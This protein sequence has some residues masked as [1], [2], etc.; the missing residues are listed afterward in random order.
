VLVRRVMS[1][2]PFAFILLELCFIVGFAMIG[3]WIAI[4]INQ[5]PV[6]GELLIG[7]ILGNIGYWLHRPLFTLIMH[8]E[9]V[10]P[11]ISDMWISGESVIQT[12][13]KLFTPSE[14]AP[15]GVGFKILE[16]ITSSG[17]SEWII[18]AAGLWLF[19]NLGVILLLFMVGLEARVDEM[20]SVG[21]HSL[22]VAVVGVVCP[23]LLGAGASIFLFPDS[24]SEV[25]L[26]LGAVLTATSVGITARVFKDLNQLKTP[27]ARLVLGAA[28]IDDILGLL[29]LSVVVGIVTAGTLE[30]FKIAYVLVLSCL[31]LGTVVMFGDRVV[32]WCVPIVSVLDRNYS[33]LLF[34]LTLAFFLSWVTDLIGLAT[35]V[36]AFAAGLILNEEYFEKHSKDKL[37]LNDL[38]GPLE[39]VFAPVFFVLVGMRV[40]LVTFL[41]LDVILTALVFTVVAILGKVIAGMFAG[42]RTD[43]L[44]VGVAMVP[45]GEV[46]LIFATIGKGLGV[47]NDSMYSAIILMV[48]ITTLVTP[49]VLNWALLRNETVP[50]QNRW[51]I[52]RS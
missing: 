2:D 17:S 25:H 22:R 35:I 26:F 41:H 8:W 20:L 34:P 46:G 48:V 12:A 31:F 27:E 14:N 18:G 40:N 52:P 5:A 19:S 51:T 29:I 3:R 49:P 33:K 6:L 39:T 47:V 23:F 42:D 28:V 16:V 21:Q 30:L 24:S 4:R 37:G 9:S 15:G 32:L 43:H 13:D 1:N 7:V 44:S 10:L 45:R 38:V 50:G 11:L 36:G